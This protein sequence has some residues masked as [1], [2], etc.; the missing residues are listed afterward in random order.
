VYLGVHWASDILAG[1][2]FAGTCVAIAAL[3]QHIPDQPDPPDPGPDAFIAIEGG[4]RG[5]SRRATP[6]TG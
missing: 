4:L 6:A 5:T 1:W 3:A 2:L